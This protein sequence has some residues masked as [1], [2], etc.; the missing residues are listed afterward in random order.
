MKIWL[1]PKAK[2]PGKN[3]SGEFGVKPQVIDR[4]LADLT[5]RPEYGTRLVEVV[6]SSPDPA[7]SAAVANAHVQAYILM[8]SERHA[9][10]SEAEQ[11]FLEKK[12][13]ELEKRIEKS[14]GF[15]SSKMS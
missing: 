1:W 8:A 6:F 3:A 11:R 14:E 2:P 4:Y 5:I 10:S 9:Q 7:L 12:L 15:R 13:I